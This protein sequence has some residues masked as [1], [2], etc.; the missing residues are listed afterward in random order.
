[1][2]PENDDSNTVGHGFTFIKL[3][4]EARQFATGVRM[5]AVVLGK[6]D[7]GLAASFGERGVGVHG[8]FDQ[9][10][11]GLIVAIEQQPAGS[12]ASSRMATLIGRVIPH[13]S[14]VVAPVVLQQR[15]PFERL[16]RC[17]RRQRLELGKAS[18]PPLYLFVL[19]APVRIPLSPP[20]PRPAS[21]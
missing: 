4:S 1:V 7:N 2:P 14:G 17:R 11:P 21:R 6:I 10:D 8:L 9:G 19:A 5:P 13:E 20:L 18:A 12:K 16:L 3:W 15:S